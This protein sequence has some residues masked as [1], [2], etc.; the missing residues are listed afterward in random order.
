MSMFEGCTSLTTPP[1]LPA[2]YIDLDWDDCYENMFKGCVSLVTA[3]NLPSR[4]LSGSCYEGMFQGCTNLTAAPKLPAAGILQ[5]NCYRNMFN[6]CTNLSS[7]PAISAT[8]VVTGSCCEMFNG[9]TKIKLS[10]TQTGSY[11]NAYRIDASDLAHIWQNA[12]TDMFAGTGGT[13]TGTPVINTTYYLDSSIEIVG[14]FNTVTADTITKYFTV[15]NGSYYFAGSGT[16]FTSNNGGVNNSTA[17]TTL[18]A[19]QNMSISFDYSYSSERNYDKL[20]LIVAGTTVAN[21]LSGA[22]TR[23]SYK[24]TLQ[25]GQQ[26]VF[27]Y[28]KDSSSHQNDDQCTFSNLQVNLQ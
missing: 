27:K 25:K 5:G 12:L 24:G 11:T 17:T 8:E 10:A 1:N 20:T 13:F 21:G 23:K 18:T 26:I 15:S 22:T 16:T 19:L 28:A 14:G 4:T 3:P 2:P 7:I 9:C 6:G